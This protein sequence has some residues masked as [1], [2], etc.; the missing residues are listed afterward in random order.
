MK[1]LFL[2]T[3]ASCLSV[4]IQAQDL[5]GNQHWGE[6][7]FTNGNILK[8][9]IEADFDSPWSIQKSIT[10]F[11]AGLLSQE[12]I[13]N[14]DK[15]DYDPKDIVTVTIGDRIYEV[16]KYSDMTA[17]GTGSIPR[18]YFLERIAD[19]KIKLFKYYQTPMFMGNT[20]E[21]EASIK[22]GRNNPDI[23]IY[24]GEEKLKAI[25]NVDM[26]EYL[27]DCT[28]VLEKYQN[29]EYGNPKI[30]AEKSKFAAKIHTEASIQAMKEW[31]K[32][33]VTDYNQTCK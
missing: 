9:V 12:K 17:A 15:V 24:K 5:T 1:N 16:Q 21:V 11:D 28:T 19:G 29:G 30:D 20:N 6:I 7:V 14:K 25:Q 10:Y 3:L 32:P 2:F 31:I 33:L 27:A 13:K 4:F 18:N 26:R 22:N 8:G 23:I